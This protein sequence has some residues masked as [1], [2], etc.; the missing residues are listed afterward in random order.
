MENRVFRRNWA[1]W[2][3]DTVLCKF[4][5]VKKRWSY[6]YGVVC[7]GIEK[8]YELT[9]DQK[10]FRYIKDSMDCFV[11][12]DGNIKYYDMEEFNLDYV[13]NGKIL[14]YL[15]EKTHEEKYAKASDILREQLNRQPRT[16][17]GGFWHKKMYPYQMWLDGLY[18]AEPFY[19]EYIKM[20]GKEKSYD[21]V[22]LQFSLID[23]HSK[24]S[25][26][27]LLYHGWDEK[28]QCFWADKE[29]GLSANFWGRSI[30]WYSCALVD[31]LDYLEN[32]K[33]REILINMVRDLADALI[34]VRSKSN[35]LWYQVMDRENDYGNYPEAS[36]SCMFTYFLLKAVRK[37]YIDDSYF[38][39]AKK[40]YYAI[41]REFIEVDQ[42]ALLNLRGTV[43]VSGLGGDKLRDG[44]YDYYI[45]EP[46][47][48]NNLLGIGAFLMAS[49]EIENAL[50]NSGTP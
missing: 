19:A 18:M 14:L 30:G 28:R 10:Y 42:N 38:D 35:F 1:V 26:S 17:D 45:S 36:C 37:G 48:T 22:V 20:F 41:V 11:Q 50:A 25:R 6:D 44:S 39:Y 27:H 16:S 33:D 5:E 32:D 34:K 4:P 49:A 9:G 12:E 40:S 7:K 21:D 23:K 31:T 2:M 47:Q 3:A 13:N 43:Y 15:Y 24:D 8:V 46:K 29:T